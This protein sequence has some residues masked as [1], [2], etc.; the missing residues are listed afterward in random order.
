LDAVIFICIKKKELLPDIVTL[1]EINGVLLRSKH[2]GGRYLKRK[3]KRI[4]G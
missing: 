3:Q 4:V 1:D 2:S